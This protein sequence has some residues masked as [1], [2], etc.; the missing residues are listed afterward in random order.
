MKVLTV[1]GN[2]EFTA[3]PKAPSDI[4]EILQDKY[5][6]KSILLEK[7]NNAFGK[8]KY[9]L[10]MYNTFLASLFFGDILVIQFPMY[11][12][13]NLL[14]K[15]FLF[16]LSA[17]RKNKTIALVH[18]I[19]GIRNDDMQSIKQD[20]D[21]LNKI[22]YVIVHNEKMRKKL[23]DYGLKS[24]TYNL[25]LFDYLCNDETKKIKEKI[26][27]KNVKIAYAGNLNKL[28]SP[29][30]HQLDCKKMKFTL[31]LYGIG[32]NNDLNEKMIYKGKKEP[33]DLPN[34]IDADLGLVWDGNYD[35]S[36][37]EKNM[38][39]YTRYNNPHKLSCYIASGKPVIVWRKSAAADFVNKYNI[40]YTIS[41][42]YDINKLNFDDYEE[43]I[44]NIEKIK[45]KVRNAFYTTK[46]MDKLLKEIKEK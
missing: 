1:K 36:D 40:G 14:N 17:V 10:K 26:D 21:R 41:S 34:E 9:R 22:G 29:F 46:V 18:D 27:K 39:G 13:T 3:G 28:K 42:I 38:K 2:G 24:K 12:T 15:V 6:A 25:E 19:D 16:F 30:I 11:E 8:I 44:K 32:I 7:G 4:I 37:S 43:K 35:E 20:I 5:N 45:N 33:N 31:Y 23:Q